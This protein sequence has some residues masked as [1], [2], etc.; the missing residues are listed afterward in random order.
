M[1]YLKF[2]LS[3]TSTFLHLSSLALMDEKGQNVPFRVLNRIEYAPQDLERVVV[4]Q[5][6]LLPGS[7]ESGT[8]AA[9]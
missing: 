6:L 8:R 2:F 7:S 3:D 9:E 1:K 4:P 5:A